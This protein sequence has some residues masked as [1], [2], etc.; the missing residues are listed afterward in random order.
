MT[1]DIQTKGLRVRN[2]QPGI[3]AGVSFRRYCQIDAENQTYL[4]K[5]VMLSPLHYRHAKDNSQETDTPAMQ[6]GRIVHTYC[7]ERRS[8]ASR[9]AVWP[10]ERRGKAWEAVARF[11]DAE[12][13]DIESPDALGIDVVDAGSRNAKE[14]KERAATAPEGIDLILLSGEWQ[15]AADFIA[16]NH[17]NTNPFSAR[18]LVTQTEWD[19]LKEQAE[20]VRNHP[21]GVFL[22]NSKRAEVEKHREL[23]LIWEEFRGATRILCKARLDMVTIAHHQNDISVWIADIKTT[24]ESTKRGF[25]RAVANLG[26]DFQREWYCRGW[27]ALTGMKLQPWQFSFLTVENAAPWDVNFYDLPD[28]ACDVGRVLVERALDLY[29]E[30]C[31]ERRWPG[32]NNDQAET[33]TGYFPRETGSETFGELH[34]VESASME[35]LHDIMH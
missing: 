27:R 17:A 8:V 10:G 30:C 34:G 21:L 33:L 2:P 9:V 15:A 4:K 28:E 29:A 23:T 3:Y 19:R 22:K 5:I 25:E 1:I 16:A 32:A 13:F 18:E 12:A 26:Y 11:Y 6:A 14:Y 35:E 7:L 20:A 31:A 24:R